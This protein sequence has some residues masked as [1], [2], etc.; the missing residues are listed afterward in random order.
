MT[1]TTPQ[2]PAELREV[3]YEFA[4]KDVPDANLLEEFV[5]RYPKYA[6][7]LTE[8]AV[9]IVVDSLRTKEVS[10]PAEALRVSPSVSRAMSVFQNALHA[11]KTGSKTSLERRAATQMAVENPFARYQRQ[12]FRESKARCMRM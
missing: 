6:D 10:I 1:K 9:E 8:F 12:G 2:S 7:D 11:V 3:L 5:G 4:L